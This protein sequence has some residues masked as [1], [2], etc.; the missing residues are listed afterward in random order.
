MRK[1]SDYLNPRGLSRKNVRP[2]V[3]EV[4]KHRGNTSDIL[5]QLPGGY[6]GRPT[7]R[8]ECPPTRPCPFVGCR[9]HMFLD[10]TPKGSIKFNFHEIEP[11]EMHNSCALD[12]VDKF[13][14]GLSLKE[15][16]GLLNVTR[17]RVRQ[18]ETTAVA[19]LSELHGIYLEGPP[20]FDKG[21]ED[22]TI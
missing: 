10:I 13:P 8:S 11:W 14:E 9:Y 16:G 15:I 3:R 7:R 22:E 20:D 4:E 5:E 21:D 12:V 6:G 1:A 18:I 17:E 19:R 2:K